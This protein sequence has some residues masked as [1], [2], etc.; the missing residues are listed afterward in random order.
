MAKQKADRRLLFVCNI[1]ENVS[2]QGKRQRPQRTYIPEQSCLQYKSR[3]LGRLL[4]A[5]STEWLSKKL[6]DVCFLSAT[7]Q[8]MLVSK[9]SDSDR[10][11]L[12]FLSSP[13]SNTKAALSGGF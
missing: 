7:S 5:E 1:S 12:T 9:E 3:P 11:E 6:T 10:S 13:V 8:K 4:V 2:E